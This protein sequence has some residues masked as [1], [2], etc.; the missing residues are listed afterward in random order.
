MMIAIRSDHERNDTI[1]AGAAA[2]RDG[3]HRRN[4]PHPLADEDWLSWMDGYDQQTVWLEQ[5]R[6]VYDPAPDGAVTPPSE[7]LPTAPVPRATPGATSESLDRG[8]V[9][10]A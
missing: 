6:G 8:T 7:P 9:P 2:A 4:N 5:G 3:V 10:S 1:R